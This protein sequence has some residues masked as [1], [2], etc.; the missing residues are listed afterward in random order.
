MRELYPEEQE[1]TINIDTEKLGGRLDQIAKKVNDKVFGQER[2]IEHAVRRLAMFEA[3]IKDPLRPVGAMIFAGPTGVGKTW[4]A[5]VIAEAWIGGKTKE[6]REPAVIIECGNLAERHNVQSL[7]GAPP[8]YI[9]FDVPP[10]LWQGYINRYHA[11]QLIEKYYKDP[12]GRAE[13]R[14]HPQQKALFLEMLLGVIA[15]H[16][17]VKSVIVFDE[18]EK[19]H[20]TV[21]NVLLNILEEG[22]ITLANGEVTDF[23]NTL[24]ILTTNVGSR[25]IQE[26]IEGHTIGFHLPKQKVEKS[27]GLDQEIYERTKRALEKEFPPELLR[28]LAREIIVFHTLRYEHYVKI[29]DMFL[30]AIAQRFSGKDSTQPLTIRYSQD[31]KDFLLKE[32]TDPRYGAGPLRA[33]SERHVLFPIA[34]AVLNKDLRVGDRVLFTVSNGE[35]HMKRARRP[36][37]IVLPEFEVWQE[38]LPLDMEA[39]LRQWGLLPNPPTRPAAQPHRRR[40]KTRNKKDEPK[41]ESKD[42][43]KDE[44]PKDGF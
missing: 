9:G 14:L 21:W 42:E 4:A 1:Y 13:K 8:S 10:L 25:D 24:F 7:T 28:R 5:K 18:I 44:P 17:G 38:K 16:H 20:P 33:L 29:L 36:R 40:M 23:S 31:F 12:I 32:G 37:G 39:I 27:N 41:D 19:A 2:A 11:E 30:E 34:V 43:P 3:G 22:K 35:P 6:G 26:L 15:E